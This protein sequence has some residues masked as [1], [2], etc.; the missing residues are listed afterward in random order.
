MLKKKENYKQLYQEFLW[1]IP[2]KYNIGYDICDRW[3]EITP[4]NIAIIDIDQD[5]SSK[6]YTFSELRALSNKFANVLKEKGLQ[7]QQNKRGERIAVLLPQSIKCAIAHISIAKLGGIAVPLFTLFQEEAL[8][9]RLRDSEA[10]G[11]HYR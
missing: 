3:A 7:K 2:E 4:E 10:E 8:L 5:G 1:D 9:H 6:E 11:N